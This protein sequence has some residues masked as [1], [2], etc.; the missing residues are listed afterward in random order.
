MS[1]PLKAQ[2]EISEKEAVERRDALLKRM[3]D[4]PPKPHKT[5]QSDKKRGG[6]RRQPKRA[7]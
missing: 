2:D 4:T 1:K 3:L 7:S 5:V 6:D